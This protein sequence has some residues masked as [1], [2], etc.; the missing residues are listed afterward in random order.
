MLRCGR[1]FIGVKGSGGKD[2]TMQTVGM[3]GGMSWVSTELYY[4]RINEAVRRAAGG[5]CSAPML[6]ESL[7]FCDLAAA[8]SDADWARVAD[9]LTASARRLEA[10]GADFILICAN[11]M[12]RVHREVEASVGVPVL[13]IADCVGRRLAAAGIEDVAL[14]GTRNVMTESWYRQRLVRHG[15][16]LLPPDLD[17]VA[18][19]DR[20]I[21]Q[22]LM[23]GKVSRDAER[24]M[25]TILTQLSQ[26][27]AEAVVLASTELS[28][29]VDTRA[30]VLPVFDSMA[31]HADEAAGM[32]LGGVA[33]PA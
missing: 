2:A 17:R 15:V 12:H 26:A 3:I 7:N 27:G 6:I 23:L 16:T 20:I 1:A 5:M 25:K 11:S 33:V 13:H 22:E 28:L 24:E 18:V 4:R 30:N 29:V 9:V 21:Y 19:I 32:I 31:A 14:V 8:S 10:A